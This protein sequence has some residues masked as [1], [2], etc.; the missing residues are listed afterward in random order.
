M[1]SEEMSQECHILLLSGLLMNIAV[2][3]EH[4]PIL[5]TSNAYTFFSFSNGVMAFL[6]YNYIL[7]Y[8]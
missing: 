8:T 7:K 5:R 6:E 2:F 3:H 1:F 4:Q